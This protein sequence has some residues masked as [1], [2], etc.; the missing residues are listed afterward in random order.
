MPSTLWTAPAPNQVGI[1]PGAT[2]NT[3]ALVDAS[4]VPACEVPPIMRV[5]STLRVKAFGDYSTSATGANITWGLYWATPS[6]AIGSATV[7]AA[8][9]AIASVSTSSVLW[10]WIFEYEGE[11][12]SLTTLSGGATGSIYGQGTIKTPTSITALAEQFL[13]ITAALR[14]VSIDTSQTMKLSLGITLSGTTGTP[15]LI[16]QHMNAELVG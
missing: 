6:T 16:C 4:P 12:R 9:N 7:I 15:A 8:S 11:I 13:P 10:P 1:G 5:G 2:A 14:T 3:A